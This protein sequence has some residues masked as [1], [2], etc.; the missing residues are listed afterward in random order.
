MRKR[1]LCWFQLRAAALLVAGTVSCGGGAEDA[2]PTTPTRTPIVV[3]AQP[4]VNLAVGGGH[5]CRLATG[6]TAFC[7]GDGSTGQLGSGSTNSQ[8][9]P[10][11]VT[12]SLVF[13]G[14]TAGEFSTCGLT[15][16]GA[17]YC[18]GENE[19]GQVGDGATTIMHLTPILVAGG[20]PFISLAAGY[21][22]VCGLTT[23]GIAYCWGYGSSG[24]LGDGTT[25]DHRS[26][27]APL[28]GGVRFA[29]LTG[30]YWHTCGLTTQG[31]AY[32]WGNNNWGQLGDSTRIARSTTGPVAGG[33]VFVN[34]R[35]GG[36]H[37]CGLSP[38]GAAYCWGWNGFGQLGDGTTTTRL[39][40]APVAVSGGLAFVSIATGWYHTCGLTAA[41]AAYCWGFNFYGQ[42]GDG[43]TTDRTTPSAVAGGLV[44]ANLAPGVDH[45]CGVTMQGT[46]YCWGSNA[47]GQLGDGTTVDHTVATPVKG[48]R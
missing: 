41:G 4:L 45:T 23:T 43:T 17:A 35:A 8:L 2:A 15:S 18:W 42:L 27:P 21:Y 19:S 38:A 47:Y 36:R 48:D 14:L 44:F 34:L 6:G 1:L 28:A 22:H 12:G 39:T 7:W 13:A 31:T 3:A 16:A 46:T 30:G 9:T 10:A 11:P 20:V 32:C 29:S 37:S 26:I 5:S 25:T 24:Q 33:F 40:P